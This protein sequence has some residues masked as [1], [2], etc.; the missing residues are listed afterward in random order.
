MIRDCRRLISGTCNGIRT[1]EGGIH[2]GNDGRGEV[3][4]GKGTHGALR[5]QILEHASEVTLVICK[6]DGSLRAKRTKNEKAA[7]NGAAD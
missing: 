3:G 6:A 5:H 2:T 4:G 1:E 7:H